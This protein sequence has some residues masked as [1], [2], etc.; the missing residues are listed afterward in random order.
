LKGSELDQKIGKQTIIA[1]GADGFATI[2]G[3]AV[4]IM[5]YIFLSG[6]KAMSVSIGVVVVSVF[7]IGMYIGKLSKRNILLSALKMA[8]F[9]LLVAAVVYL[10]QSVIVS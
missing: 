7:L 2:I 1:G 6:L 3:G 8:V 9:G 5:P 10:I 4:P